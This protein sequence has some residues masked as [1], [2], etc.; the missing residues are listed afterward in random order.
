V[1]L[2]YIDRYHLGDVFFLRAL[3]VSLARLARERRPAVVLHGPGEFTAR[4]LEAEGI[5]LDNRDVRALNEEGSREAALRAIRELNQRLVNI[6]T[7]ALAP[8]ISI[9]PAS[10]RLFVE[11]G[12]RLVKRRSAWLAELTT[13][14]AIPVLSSTVSSDLGPMVAS[15]REVLAAALADEA[16]ITPVIFTKTSLPG[17]MAGKEPVAT[18]S[19]DDPKIEKCIRDAE[20][21]ELLTLARVNYVITNASGPGASGQPLGTMVSFND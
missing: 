8:A 7:E 11:T 5:F 19:P 3:G 15:D 12:G 14:P 17:I 1:Y 21:L 10:Q 18:I 6:F 20:V 9:D 4:A 16:E 2:L 13:M